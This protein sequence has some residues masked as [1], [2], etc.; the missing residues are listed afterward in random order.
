MDEKRPGLRLKASAR[1]ETS[2]HL[3][4]ARTLSPNTTGRRGA[5]FEALLD[6]ID[7][8]IGETFERIEVTADGVDWWEREGLRPPPGPALRLSRACLR[9]M[10]RLVYTLANI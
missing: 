5:A 2:L 8:V 10:D 6:R 4:A 9:R 3:P 7:D 1:S